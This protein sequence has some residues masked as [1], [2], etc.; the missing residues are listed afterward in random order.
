MSPANGAR[1]RVAQVACRRPPSCAMAA[2]TS[3]SDVPFGAPGSRSRC[4]N[5][6]PRRAGT[7]ASDSSPTT[8]PS[9]SATSRRRCS[10]YRSGATSTMK[11]I[12]GMVRDASHR[13]TDRRELPAQRA[14]PGQRVGVTSRMATPFARARRSCSRSERCV[15]TCA[16]Q[17]RGSHTG[18]SPTSHRRSDGDDART[19]SVA[20]KQA[21]LPAAAAARRS[22]PPRPPRPPVRRSVRRRQPTPRPCP[23]TPRDR[24][25]RRTSGPG[26]ARAPGRRCQRD[27]AARATASRAHRS[28]RR[29]VR[30][31][32]RR[33]D[34]AA[35][36]WPAC[37]G[38]RRPSAAARPAS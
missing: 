37:P 35:T 22:V 27:R 29:R 8:C 23:R 18:C 24:D 32:G 7:G 25:R 15:P 17:R 6:Q 28:G 2:S 38:R 12:G 1:P 3:D 21:R 13:R 9:R 20:K 19:P 33:C 30:V 36:R 34:G 10:R 11:C 16:A 5:N 31:S 26:P 4:S 14:V